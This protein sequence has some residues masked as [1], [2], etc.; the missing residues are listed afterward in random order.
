LLAQIFVVRDTVSS[1][2][3][4]D[5]GLHLS[6][7]GACFF[8]QA[9]ALDERRVKFLPEYVHGGASIRPGEQDDTDFPSVKEVWFRGCHSDMCVSMFSPPHGLFICL[10]VNS[11]GKNGVKT[12]LTTFHMPLFWMKHEAMIADL[13]FSTDGIEWKWEWL[14][15]SEILRKKFPEQFEMEFPK[16]WRFFEYWPV[17]QLEYKDETSKSR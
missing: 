2:A 14:E 6:D 11:G 10:F 1:V 8:R 4:P 12:E 15:L 3:S 5:D 16:M 17:L 9:L 13:S 7:S